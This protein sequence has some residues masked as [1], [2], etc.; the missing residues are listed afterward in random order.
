MIRLL[1]AAA[2]FMV[3][4]S[5]GAAHLISDPEC[6]WNNTEPAACPRGAEYSKD[7]GATWETMGVRELKNGKEIRVHHNMNLFPNGHQEIL[8]RYVNPWG[9]GPSVPFVFTK[10]APKAPAGLSITLN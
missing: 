3:V 2:M 9:E 1:L 7:S 6:N 10:S 4:S 8:V 5:V